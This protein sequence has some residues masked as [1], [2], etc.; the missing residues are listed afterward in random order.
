MVWKDCG[1]KIEIH[2]IGALGTYNCLGYMDFKFIK[3]YD[4]RD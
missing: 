4:F 1:I 2:G 3:M